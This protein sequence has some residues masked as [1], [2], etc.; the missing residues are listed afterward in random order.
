MAK[1]RIFISSTY[2]DL[3]YVR[4]D[5][6][7]F[8]LNLGYESIRHESGQIPY[9]KE[10]PLEESAYR[11][12]S[13]SDIIICI[14]GGR[15]GT[16]SS[17]REGSIT[18]N[19]LEQALK[20]GIQV[21]I[22]IEANVYTEFGTYKLNKDSKDIKY[23]FVD[24]P[25]VY[26]FLEKIISLPNNNP[27]QAFKNSTD[28]SN[29]LRIQWAGLF[30]SFLQEKR[31]I[32]EINVLDEMKVVSSTLKETVTFLTTERKNKDEAIRNIILANHPAFRTFAKLTGTSY[33]VFFTNLKELNDWLKARSYE[34]ID[35]QYLDPD[36]KAEW[37]NH[38]KE[39]GIKLTEDIFDSTGRLKTYS[40]DEWKKEWL[41]AFES[42][43]PPPNAPEDDLPF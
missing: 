4:E 11:E 32:S 41:S 37:I 5:L 9:I 8:V 31:R 13:L 21:Y 1:P 30:Q 24:N 19:E 26:Q 39:K 12:V 28:I 15:Y 2:Y 14:I 35:E 3:H 33:R 10:S 16:E 36:S 42:P 22:F 23:Q 17:T 40:E 20:R 27:I 34:P 7:R 25:L 29:F 6:E 43:E 38:D 18:Q